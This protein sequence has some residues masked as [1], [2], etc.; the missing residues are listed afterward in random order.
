[1]ESTIVLTL[2]SCL[3]HRDRFFLEKCNQ[4][5]PAWNC[6]SL[7]FCHQDSVPHSQTSFEPTKPREKTCTNYFICSSTK[8]CS[9]TQRSD[10]TFSYSFF[11][12]R[13]FRT[14]TGRWL[15]RMALARRTAACQKIG[16]ID[17]SF[18]G[19]CPTSL[20]GL[21]GKSCDANFKN[22]SSPFSG[23]SCTGCCG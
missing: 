22:L 21:A 12:P 4:P 17:C 10:S 7:R 2:S 3:C 5:S 14:T 23:P 6:T 1:M 15:F 11:L 16:S 8:S 19:A 20:L 9:E 13:V 18:S